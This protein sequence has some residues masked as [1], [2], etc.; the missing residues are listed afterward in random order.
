MSGKRPQGAFTLIELLVVIAIIG[1]LAALILSA[2]SKAKMRATVATCLANQKQLLTAWIMC[3][4]DHGDLIPGS[5]CTSAEDWRI[6]VMALT[7]TPPGN[8]DALSTAIW[9]AEEGYKE[10]QLYPFAQNPKIIHCPGDPRPLSTLGNPGFDSYSMP[11][12]LNSASGHFVPIV[13]RSQIMHPSDRFVF[14]EEFDSRGDN[15][16]S[17]WMNDTGPT[18]GY[19]GSSWID[20][21]ATFHNRASSFAWADGHASNRRWLADDTVDFAA[22][23]DP[24]KFN[25]PP[26]PPDNPDIMFVAT[27]FPFLGSSASDPGNP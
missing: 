19:Q 26:D 20:S 17:W 25:H 18:V 22:S 5:D 10:G 14:I 23:T 12:G 4:D 11:E 8:L 6:D 7:A 16:G 3:A 27:G 2:L 1:I 13:K 9:Q 15:Q 24:S 21:P